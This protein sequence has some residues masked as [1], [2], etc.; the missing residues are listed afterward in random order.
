MCIVKVVKKPYKNESSIFNLIN[1]ALT[2]KR[3]NTAV[4]YYGGYNVD[5]LRAA[6]QFLLVKQYFQKWDGRKMRHFVV[7]FDENITPYDAYILGWQIA[8]L[9]ADRYQ[10]VFVVHEDTDNVHIHFVFNTVSFVDG[11]K[12]SESYSDLYK[13]NVYVDKTY[14]EYMEHVQR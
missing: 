14:N 6:E 2:D 11:L 7:S 4:R 5:V 9:Y 1:Y 10:I 12:Y 3:S 8:A 13:L